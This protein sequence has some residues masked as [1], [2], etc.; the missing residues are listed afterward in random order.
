M[1]SVIC[2]HCLGKQQGVLFMSNV[3]YLMQQPHARMDVVR[4]FTNRL[5]STFKKAYFKGVKTE[6]ISNNTS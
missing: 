4:H 3:T 5:K 2:S 6:F 1:C